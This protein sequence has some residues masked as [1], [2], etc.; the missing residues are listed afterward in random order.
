[1]KNYFIVEQRY[2]QWW[3]WSIL[4]GIL[5]ISMYDIFKQLY[6]GETFGSRP[7]ADFGLIVF[8]GLA[9]GLIIIFRVIRLRTEINKD[10]IRIE[11]FPFL[12]KSIIWEEVEAINTITYG[13]IGGWGLIPYSPYGKVY[14]IKGNKGLLIDLKNG[15]KLLVGSQ[16]EPEMRVIL[17]SIKQRKEV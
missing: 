3:V 12:I 13:F 6:L 1:M 9:L 8:G 15:R 17:K 16:K 14:N 10:K 7:M 4:I 5:G 2:T 11:F